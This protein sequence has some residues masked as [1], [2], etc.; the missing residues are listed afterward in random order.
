MIIVITGPLGSGKSTALLNIA[1]AAKNAGKSAGG[2]ISARVM[3]ESGERYGYKLIDIAGDFSSELLAANN[4]QPEAVAAVENEDVTQF[5]C[6]LFLNAAVDKGNSLIQ[7][8]IGADI[9]IVDEVGIWE[10][11]GG[12]W[13]P[14]M[15]AV[16]KS[17]GT[18]ILSVRE[19]AVPYLEEAW[20][21]KPDHIIAAGPGAEDEILK[22]IKVDHA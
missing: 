12:G 7:K 10:L 22:L 21:I 16:A 1:R 19:Q 13:A 15:P 20:G 4:E 14:S 11:K 17:T 18:V 5:S 9:L 3:L 6:F 2:V 8:G